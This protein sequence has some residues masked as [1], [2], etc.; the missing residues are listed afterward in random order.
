MT[1]LSMCA[2]YI[3]PSYFF[4]QKLKTYLNSTLMCHKNNP[5]YE[6]LKNLKIV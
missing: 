5:E 3:S 2:E 1:K 4:F 6:G